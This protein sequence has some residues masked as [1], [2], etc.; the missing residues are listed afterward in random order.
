MNKIT[1]CLFSVVSAPAKLLWWVNYKAS[2]LLRHF[3]SLG[4]RSYYQ[5]IILDDTSDTQI[6]LYS[7]V[8]G[9]SVEPAT[10]TYFQIAIVFLFFRV[11]LE[12]ISL[13][14]LGQCPLSFSIKE[15]SKKSKLANA[16]IATA[17]LFVCNP[18]VTVSLVRKGF[19]FG[20][21]AL[22]HYSEVDYPFYT[23]FSKNDQ[24]FGFIHPQA[25]LGIFPVFRTVWV[26]GC[27][28]SESST[29]YILA[30]NP[31]MLPVFVETGLCKDRLR[32]L[33]KHSVLSR[34]VK[35]MPPRSS[36]VFT[37][38]KSAFDAS[39]AA[40]PYM[41]PVCGNNSKPLLICALS[42]SPSL[43]QPDDLLTCLHS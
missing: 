32:P 22:H 5:A 15:A 40:F 13:E 17:N 3:P 34:K 9:L 25:K 14:S 12:S 30:T 36:F 26:S 31:S 10:T 23:S 28:V 37:F 20:P 27:E 29:V 38:A 1:G 11:K 7:P 19:H 2:M 43:V 16:L 21:I 18:I 4:L 33:A 42:S 39:I 35:L 6:H 24:C 41:T 8:L